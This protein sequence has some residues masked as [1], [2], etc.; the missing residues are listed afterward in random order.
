MSF[1]LLLSAVLG[2]VYPQVSTS[3][4]QG[5]AT[6]KNKDGVKAAV[7]LKGVQ[8]GASYDGLQA[9]IRVPGIKRRFQPGERMPLECYL[10][11]ASDHDIA[12]T[13]TARYYWDER[14]EVRD[15]T[16]PEVPREVGGALLTGLDAALSLLLKPGESV[17]FPHAGLG[18]GGNQWP[19]LKEPKPGC[20]TVRQKFL[21]R[22]STPAEVKRLAL[23][24]HQKDK[25]IIEPMAVTLLKVD[26][27]PYQGEVTCIP[28]SNETSSLTT[29]DATFEILA[30]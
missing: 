25:V 5:P 3:G 16:E 4:N 21:Y 24:S 23:R 8:W 1:V 7:S 28:F 18:L 27:T 30:Q 19:H 26:G 2:F 13:Y 6:Q 10:R 11:N 17:V 15:L 14:P 20:Y 12:F 29:G 9:G 22:L